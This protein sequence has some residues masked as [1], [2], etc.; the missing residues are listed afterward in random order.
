MSMKRNMELARKILLEMERRSEDEETRPIQIEGFSD[1]EIAYHIMLLADANLI[2]ALDAS[3]GSERCWMPQTLTW[4]GHEFLDSS[5]DE[6][7]WRHA[8]S[9]VA[10]K[11]GGL[12]FEL[13][14]AYLIS[15]GKQSLGLP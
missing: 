14:K 6:S 4:Q 11:T 9:T 5:R 1:S 15:L 13:L 10:N 2:N 7:S 3:A 8:M 12:A